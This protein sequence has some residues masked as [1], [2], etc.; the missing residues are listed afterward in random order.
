M[1]SSL[2]K[3]FFYAI[4]LILCT[5]TSNT[6][7]GSA[8]DL[9]TADSKLVFSQPPS[10]THSQQPH[11]TKFCLTMIVKNESA[12]IERCLNSVKDDVDYICICDTGSSDDTVKIIKRFMQENSIPGEIF[13]HEWKNFGHN[14]TLSGRAAQQT[15]KKFALPLEN[16]YLLLL[17]ADM[18]LEPHSNFDKEILTED[19]YLIMQKSS[20][21]SYYNLRLLRA[22]L[23]WECKGVTHEYWTCDVPYQSSRLDGIVVDDREDGGSKSDKFERD[24]RLLEQGLKENPNNERYL[25]YLAQSYRCIRDHDEAIK[26]Y[27]ARIEKGGWKEEV[28]YSKYMI[29]QCYQEKG[30]WNN[31]LAYYLD[32]YNFNPDRAEPLHDIAVYYRQNSKNELAYLFAKQGLCIP[33]PRDQYLF[34]SHPVYEHQFDEEIAIAAY[35]TRFKEDGFISVNKLLLKKNIPGYIKDFA[36]RT[37]LFYIPTLK[38]AQFDPITI[39]LPKIREGFSESFCPM[40]PS[41]EKVEDGYLLICRTVNYI[42]VG[43]RDHKSCDIF[44]PTIRTKNFLV[45]YDKNFNVISQNEIVENLIRYRKNKMSVEGLEDC[46]LIKHNEDFWFTCTAY[47]MNPQGT[48]QIALCKLDNNYSKEKINVVKLVPLIGPDPQRCEKNWLPFIKDNAIHVIY[49]CDPF[50]VYKPDLISGKCEEVIHYNPKYDF[51]SFR[52]SA[53]P[54]AFDNGYLLIVHEV[55]LTNQRY[56]LHRFVYLDKNFNATK[57]SKPFTFLHQGIEYTCGMTIDHSGTKLIIPIGIEDRNAHLCTIGL[58]IVHSMLEPLPSI[59]EE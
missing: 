11:K 24:I 29:G 32:A 27:L 35:Y 34:I 8:V 42:Q 25:F 45:H 33:Y 5:V 50:I 47:N 55:A 23:P 20:A 57:V 15:L 28:W 41:I 44:D 2:I 49:S 54:I 10:T 18:V 30:D 58:E 13:I 40:N 36:Y 52:G 38:N 53:P 39:N 14:R 16:T 6:C 12:I 46:R 19:A 7:Y 51:S 26:W 43:G 22:S 4:S 9:L 31:A 48:P 1:P 56:Y 37:A 17:D 21:I 3:L 59:L